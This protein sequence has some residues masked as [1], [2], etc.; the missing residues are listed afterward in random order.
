MRGVSA[1]RDAFRRARAESRAALILYWPVGYP[2]L[3][4]SVRLVVAM[5]RS[6]A[7]LIELGVPFSDP[8]ADGPTIQRATYRALQQGVRTGEVLEAVARIREA[9][10]EQPLCLMTYTNPVLAWGPEAFVESVQ[11]HG[12]DGLIVPDLPLEESAPFQS[13]LGALGLAWVPLAAPTT[14]DARLAAL[15]AGATGFLYFVSVTGITGARERLPDEVVGHLRRA[16]RMADGVP[17]AVGFGV[18]RPEHVAWLATEADGVVVGSALIHRAESADFG[19]EAVEAFVRA[20]RDAGRWAL[21]DG[22]SPR[23]SRI[24]K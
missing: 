15:A 7:D 14:P 2:D 18:S 8:L 20:L 4:T 5:A 22:L 11:K 1:V 9:G 12:A 19:G 16:R 13:A 24:G 21:T 23:S 3:A 17:V 6:G 10:V